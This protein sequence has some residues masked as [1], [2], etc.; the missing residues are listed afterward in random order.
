MIPNR[1]ATA[2]DIIAHFYPK[3]EHEVD[4]YGRTHS[5]KGCIDKVLANLNRGHVEF[6][7]Q[8]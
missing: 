1:A 2:F 8:V 7:A 6:I 5:Q 4:D 3:G